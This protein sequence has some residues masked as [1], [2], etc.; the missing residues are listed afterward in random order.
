MSQLNPLDNDLALM[1]KNLNTRLSAL[2]N[3]RQP[4]I[5]EWMQ[6]TDNFTVNNN[7]AFNYNNTNSIV[8]SYIRAGTWIKWKQV[9]D[10]SYRYA[11]IANS[12]SS[13]SVMGIIYV[14][15]NF[16]NAVNIIEFWYSNKPNPLGAPTGFN[17]G[18]LMTVPTQSGNSFSITIAAGLAMSVVG[19]ILILTGSLGVITLTAGGPALNFVVYFPI[20][21]P[22]N[23]YAPNFASA[24]NSSVQTL[25]NA[26]AGSG[27]GTYTNYVYV[28]NNG[29]NYQIAM[30]VN[31]P[32]FSVGQGA[33][34]LF[35]MFLPILS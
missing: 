9:G 20:V 3:T 14:G 18:G 31:V 26:S 10:S 12:T 30:G 7:W 19:N 35:Q 28:G 33:S 23:L 4:Y 24:G 6:I 2:E 25:T 15:Y 34:S 11:I 8:T 16:T 17:I 32:S 29:G 5:S 13:N 1:L 27:G 22:T 21:D